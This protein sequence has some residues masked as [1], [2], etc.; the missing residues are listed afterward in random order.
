MNKII[1]VLV[2]VFVLTS[3]VGLLA[4]N[5]TLKAL[6]KANIDTL[7]TQKTPRNPRVATIM[8][9]VLPGSGQVYNRKYW[10]PIIIYGGFA[11]VV[12]Y[13]RDQH[14][15]YKKYYHD[16]A[17]IEIDSLGNQYISGI[18][19][20]NAKDVSGIE[21]GLYRTRRARDLTIFIGVLWWGLNVVDAYVDAE[22]S[23][24]DVSDDLSMNIS[25]IYNN[26][27]G[28]NYCGISFKFYFK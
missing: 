1:F 2:L 28:Q 11:P 13:A 12:Y 14:Q 24:F 6:E 17:L 7:K 5:D 9:S 20:S 21:S 4:Q 15:N 25:P 3:R 19:Q 26:I 23:N 27:S 18:L 22:L 8:S 10:K 16:A